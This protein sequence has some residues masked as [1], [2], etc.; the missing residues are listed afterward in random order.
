MA[1][2]FVL[3]VAAA[4]LLNFCLYPFLIRFRN[5]LKAR[6]L[7]CA[8]V[9]SHPSGFLFGLSN[10]REILKADKEKTVPKIFEKRFQRVSEQEG[11]S[12]S[13]FRMRQVGR[14]F[15]ATADPRNIQAVLATQ[16][17]D[18]GLGIGRWQSLRPL[19]GTAIVSFLT[20]RILLL[21]LLTSYI[22]HLRWR[23]VGAF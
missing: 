5:A 7:G 19:L 22:V 13:T 1:L 3:C 6:N 18:F 4:I 11:R 8:Q 16:F 17:K 15:L 2:S 20:M 9:P 14:E 23:D 21:P 12:V 10:I